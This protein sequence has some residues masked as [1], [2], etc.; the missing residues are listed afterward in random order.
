MNE[1]P[2]FPHSFP[3]AGRWL[4]EVVRVQEQIWVFQCNFSG[5]FAQFGSSHSVPG[6]DNA[7]RSYKEQNLY[8]LLKDLFFVLSLWIRILCCLKQCCIIHWGDTMPVSQQLR[9][10]PMAFR[11][12]IGNTLSSTCVPSPPIRSLDFRRVWQTQVKLKDIFSEQNS[13]WQQNKIKYWFTIAN[14]RLIHSYTL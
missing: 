6:D 11:D 8:L 2:A 9:I 7:Q 10:Y 14:N 4:P 13:Y 3:R 5:S 12:S 1:G